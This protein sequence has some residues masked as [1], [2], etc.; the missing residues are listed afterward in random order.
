MVLKIDIRS[1][2]QITFG[3]IK[4]GDQ[5]T[6]IRPE[7]CDLSQSPGF[8]PVLERFVGQRLTVREVAKASDYDLVLVHELPYPLRASWLLR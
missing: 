8:H 3:P 6:L 2:Q 1:R 7:E 5:A 4:V